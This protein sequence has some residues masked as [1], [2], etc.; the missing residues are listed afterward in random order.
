[1]DTLRHPGKQAGSQCHFQK[2]QTPGCAAGGPVFVFSLATS[3]RKIG[4]AK[5]SASKMSFDFPEN[6]ARLIFDRW[7]DLPFAPGYQPTQRPLLTVLSTL[8]NTCFFASL[9]KEEARTTQFDLALC[10]PA[11]LPE[12]AFRYSKFTKLFNLIGFDDPRKLSVNE[13][14]RLAPACDPEKTIIL[15]GYD[16]KTDSLSLWGVA[17]VG[18]RPSC[19]DMRLSQLRIRVFGPGDMKITLHDRFLCTYQDGTISCPERSLINTGCVYDFFKQTSLLLCREV[20]AATGELPDDEPGEGRDY[21]AMGYLFALQEIIERVQR[22]KHG[23][24]ILIVPEETSYPS[25]ANTTIKYRCRDKTAWGCLRGKLILHDRFYAALEVAS[26]GG[27]NPEE[28]HRLQS[29]REDVEA[30]LSDALD[31]LARFTAVDGAVLMTRK[32]ELLG[33]GTVIQLPQKAEYRVRRCADR[34]ASQTSDTVIEAYGTRHR[35]A[36]EFCYRCAPS[37]A[38]IVSQDGGLKTVTRVGEDVCFWENPLFD[39]STEV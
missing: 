39:C 12:A 1:M 2:R 36:F 8:L 35:S 4:A 7:P 27:C 6:I 38:I 32:L 37:V 10:C 33:F 16:S 21:R 23:G 22:L 19:A 15:V 3:E 9:K 20:K 24:C 14:V 18:R 34:Q 25:L 29:E 11:D 13:V 31:A 28:V 5:P 26:A 30:G 17:D